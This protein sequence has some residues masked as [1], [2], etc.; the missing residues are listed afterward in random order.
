M[1]RYF[2]VS[3]PTHAHCPTMIMDFSEALKQFWRIPFTTPRL[4]GSYMEVVQ[5]NLMNLKLTT[6]CE[7]DVSTVAVYLYLLLAIPVVRRRAAEWAL[8]CACNIS[9]ASESG[10]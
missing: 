9:R 7:M 2:L 3:G 5:G 10:H 4:L 6:E 1:Y 8:C